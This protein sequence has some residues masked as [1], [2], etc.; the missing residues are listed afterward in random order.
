MLERD[1]TV[2]KGRPGIEELKNASQ[3]LAQQT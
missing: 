1:R 3:K 2:V